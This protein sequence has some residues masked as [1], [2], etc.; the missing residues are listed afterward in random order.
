MIR[1]LNRRCLRT[2]DVYFNELPFLVDEDTP[3]QSRSTLRDGN[4]AMTEECK[5][6]LLRVRATESHCSVQL[7][8]AFI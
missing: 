4:E 6:Y 5:V 8:C 2:I 3:G 7:I 1:N